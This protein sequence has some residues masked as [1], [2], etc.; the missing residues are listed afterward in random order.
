MY[1]PEPCPPPALQIRSGLS[2]LG[3]VA[4][5]TRQAYLVFRLNSTNA[6]DLAFLAPFQHL[7]RIEVSGNE[8][9]SMRHLSG[10]A[11]LV[12]LN[13]SGTTPLLRMRYECRDSSAAGNAAASDRSAK[14]AAAGRNVCA[15]PRR[16]ITPQ[17]MR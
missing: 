10:R 6:T 15:L 3:R 4:D 5:G 1:L 2:G 8:L 9:S 17:T 7:Q 16:P 12:H 14:P 11:P 13:V